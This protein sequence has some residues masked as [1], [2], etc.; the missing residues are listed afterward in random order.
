MHAEVSAELSAS[1]KL[2]CS[3]V[4]YRHCIYFCMSPLLLSDIVGFISFVQS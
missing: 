1:S 2:L 3:F 4:R